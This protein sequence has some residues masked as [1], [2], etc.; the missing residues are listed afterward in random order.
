MSQ[1]CRA[2]SGK[3][4]LHS[5]RV[6]ARAFFGGPVVLA[7]AGL[8]ETGVSGEVCVDCGHIEFKATDLAKLQ[9]A[10]AAHEPL[11]LRA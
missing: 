11:D 5:E 2:C 9:T 6:W 8:A 1:T 10:F 4:V 3:R 7:V